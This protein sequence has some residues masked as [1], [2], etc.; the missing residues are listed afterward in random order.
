MNTYAGFDIGRWRVATDADKAAV[1][2]REDEQRERVQRSN[3]RHGNYRCAYCG[4]S[5]VELTSIHSF[6]VMDIFG[7]ASSKLVHHIKTE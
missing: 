3:M 5:P 2:E 7:A 1:K 4:I 6:H